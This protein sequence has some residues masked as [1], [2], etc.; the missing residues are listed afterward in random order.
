MAIGILELALVV[1]IIPVLVLLL[2]II[3]VWGIVK[4]V[5]GSATSRDPEFGASE[6]RLMQEVHQGLS[7]LEERVASLETILIEQGRKE[8]E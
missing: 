6:T 5:S 1:L 3:I 4:I 7:K 8:Q 2:P